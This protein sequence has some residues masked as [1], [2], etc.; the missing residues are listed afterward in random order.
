M[1]THNKTQLRK[2]AREHLLESLAVAFYRIDEGRYGRGDQ[3]EQLLEM[4]DT[5]ME[6]IEK[7]CGQEPGSWS[8]NA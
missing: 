6:R 2:Q 5:E 8:R 3:D 4:M 1:K 7:L